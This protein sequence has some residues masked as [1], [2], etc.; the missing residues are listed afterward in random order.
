MPTDGGEAIQLTWGGGWGPLES[1][2]GKFIYYPKALGGASV[3][4]LPVEGGQAAKVFENLSDLRNIVSKGISFPNTVR[5]GLA[6]QIEFL[7]FATNH[8]RRVASFGN[9]SVV[10][11]ICLRMADGSCIPNSIKQAP[12]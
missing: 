7:D 2:D 3:W 1:P 11:W 9:L 5:L 12:S 4:G 10:A 6:L 8:T